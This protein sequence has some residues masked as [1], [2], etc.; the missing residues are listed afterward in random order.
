MKTGELLLKGE[1][2]KYSQDDIPDI[3][4]NILGIFYENMELGKG[5]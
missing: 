4:K 1:P 2:L 5:W 3:R